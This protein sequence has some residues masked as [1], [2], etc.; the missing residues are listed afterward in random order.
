VAI[1]LSLH[2]KLDTGMHDVE[3]AEEIIQ[4]PG[5]WGQITVSFQDNKLIST[6]LY[7]ASTVVM[8]ISMRMVL[9]L[10]MLFWDTVS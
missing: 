7:P 6:F 10:N 2:C 4:F 3:V 8:K 5:P 9:D 1:W